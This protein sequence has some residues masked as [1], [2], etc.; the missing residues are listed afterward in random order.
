MDHL[1]RRTL[2]RASLGAA[3]GTLARPFVANAAAETMELW[4][5]QGYVKPED[6]VIRK[7]VSEYEK[8]S[9][10]KVDLS[11]TPDAP[12][13]Q[14][15]IAAITSGVVPDAIWTTQPTVEIVPRQAWDGTLED[16]T[17][18]IETQKEHYSETALAAAYCYNNVEKRRSYY[19]VPFDQG[20]VP[21]HIWGSLIEKAGA[22][23]SDIPKTWTKFL[24]FF[25][26]LQKPL[27][28]K[29]MRHTYSYGWEISTNANDPINAFNQFMVAYGGEGIVTKDG[30]LH[31]DDPQVK[32]AVIRAIDRFVSDFKGGYVPPSALNW[33]DADDNNA[34]HSQLCLIDFD[35]TLSTE[36]AMKTANPKAFWHEVITAGIPLNDEGKPIPNILGPQSIIIPKGAKNVK[37][38]KEFAKF[39]IQPEVNSEFVKGG[40]GRWL[41]VF[42]AQV[43]NDP[44]WT[45]PKIDPHRPPYVKEGFDSPTIPDWA[46][47]NPG[48]AEVETQHHLNVAFDD[49]VTGRMSAKA[50]TA[51]AFKE[52]E[53]IFA[54]YQIKAG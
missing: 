46:V 10:T 34:F 27:R 41:P 32:E 23:P 17:D 15:V 28:A 6:V 3:A 52:M 22:K 13:G 25:R 38:A 54:R 5:T 45:D 24:D 49:V 19:G 44:W 36:M 2:L 1:T 48:W 14:K 51:K 43:K 40:L 35:G 50:A 33:G 29:G 8:Q 47:Y 4:W 42:P 18:V 16:V 20:A 53:T 39:M 9:G 37:A 11:I 26:P 31:T 30:K 7:L 12:L 21:F